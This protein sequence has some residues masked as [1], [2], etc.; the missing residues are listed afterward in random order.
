MK[1]TE[2]AKVE[3]RYARRSVGDRYSLLRPENWLTIQE[4]QRAII[5]IF[6][7]NLGWNDLSGIKLTEIGCG[8][9]G[10]L[11]EFLRLGFLSQHLCGIELL[12]ERAA[13]ARGNLPQS[14]VLLEG[15]AASIDLPAMSQ[16][17]VYQSVVFS[18]ILD[19]EFQKKLANRM[20]LW[21]KP[22]GGVLWYDF[23]YNNP[24][25]P[26]VRG[27]SIK[28]VRELFPNGDMIIRKITL[29]PPLSRMF[30]RFHPYAYY[31]LNFFPML[32][33]HRL[34]WIGKSVE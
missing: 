25:N 10:N 18:S 2:I 21:V 19:N 5:Q 17:V 9:G 27:V 22:G 30:S 14:L 26:D 32:R 20:W 11:L 6:S 13:Q 7:H 8:D 3:K 16:D 28:R 1:E 12:T 24:L 29:A 23:V 31:L 33:T 4:R 34:I 15:D